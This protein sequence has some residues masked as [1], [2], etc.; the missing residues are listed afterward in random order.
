M[1]HITSKNE[2]PQNIKILEKNDLCLLPPRP[3]HGHK[4]TFGHALIVG[5]SLG[6]SGAGYLAAKAAY[7]AGCGLVEI[8]CPLDNR[9][10]YQMQLPEAI[11]TCYHNGN[12]AEL[13]HRALPRVDAIGI[14]MGL[15]RGFA[16]A[17]LV[18]V[19]LAESEKPLILDADALNFIAAD[20]QLFDRLRKRNGNTVLTPHLGEMSRLIKR[21]VS[22][23]EADPIRITV[24]FAKKSRAVIVLKSHHTVITDGETVY[25]NTFGNNGMATGGSGDVLAGVITSLTAGGTD[26]LTAAKCGVLAHALAGDAA[27]TDLGHRG[28]MA[29]DIAD[30]VG[31]IM[32]A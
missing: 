8:F 5:G 6:M 21:P 11:L 30:R 18:R 24:D 4:G 13:L 19:A 27:A 31:K 9:I 32:E 29:S 22:E 14:G 12:A 2:I 1:E 23:I 28:V 25:V 10:I 17:S 15:G 20:I 7:R 3:E 26:V 16:A